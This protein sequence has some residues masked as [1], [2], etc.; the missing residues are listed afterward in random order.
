MQREEYFY[1]L[2][3]NCFCSWCCCL[4]QSIQRGL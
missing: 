1:Q 2:K 3:F 4:S